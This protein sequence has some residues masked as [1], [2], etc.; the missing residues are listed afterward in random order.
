MASP[1]AKDFSH[2]ESLNQCMMGKETKKGEKKII[3]FSKRRSFPL[4]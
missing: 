1:E 2:E 4:K 3:V